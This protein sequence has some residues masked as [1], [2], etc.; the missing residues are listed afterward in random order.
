[1]RRL[2]QPSSL[3]VV[4]FIC[5]IVVLLGN[6]LIRALR[7]RFTLK[8]LG[9]RLG[10]AIRRTRS[11]GRRLHSLSGSWRASKNA[12]NAQQERVREERQ[13][14]ESGQLEFADGVLSSRGGPGGLWCLRLSDIAVIG[15]YT[16]GNGP[17]ADDYF[18][19]FVRPDGS[20]FEA[21]VYAVG[22]NAALANLGR[23]MEVTLCPALVWSTDWRTN[24]LWPAALKG[25]L[26]FA[27]VAVAPTGPW[28]ALCALLGMD[29]RL[30][31]LSPEIQKFLGLAAR[32]GCHPRR[33]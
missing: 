15:E 11:G 10:F 6:A 18:V 3:W 31:V 28:A 14:Q 25:R 23:A 26:L 1:M 7:R 8:G 19:V 24:V 29:R 22:R 16:N 17:F 9:F 4:A 32:E 33:G 2:A 5:A 27:S 13:R 12:W 30:T 21:S 20:A